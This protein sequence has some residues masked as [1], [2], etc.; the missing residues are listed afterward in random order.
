MN[1]KVKK[2]GDW[3]PIW[4]FFF[5]VCVYNIDICLFFAQVKERERVGPS[6]IF[7]GQD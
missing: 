4:L 5:G 3:K 7:K 6:R 2:I 1:E